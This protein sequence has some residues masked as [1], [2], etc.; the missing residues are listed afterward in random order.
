M[1]KRY[2]LKATVYDKKGNVL[3]IGYNSYTKTHPMMYRFGKK[4]KQ[5]PAK[6][7]LHAEV[8]A[9]IK[10]MKVGVPYSI[11][12]ERYNKNGDPMNARPCEICQAVIELAGI[13]K[14]T[15]TIG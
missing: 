13:K 6:V 5:H 11:N 1:S 10:A 9:C 14:I 3:A 12:I 8:A 15:Y 4:T 2:D 7:F